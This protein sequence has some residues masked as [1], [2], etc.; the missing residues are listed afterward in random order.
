MNY[1]LFL[2]AFRE[3]YRGISEYLFSYLREELQ[4][5]ILHVIYTKLTFPLHFMGGTQLRLSHLLPRF[6]EDLDFA[7]DKP[8]P[9]FDVSALLELITNAFKE[10]ESGFRC[11]VKANTNR[12]V[13][14]IMVTFAGVLYDVGLPAM[15]DQT[16][17]IKLEVD[18]RPPANARI[19]KKEYRS[20][21]G[22]YFLETF[23]L[24]TGFAGKLGAVVE[25][26]YQKGRDY[27]DLQWYLGRK[28]KVPIN[29]AY[30]NANAVLMNRP[31]MRD[32]AELL[33][34]VE[35]KLK[36]LNLDLLK[37]DLSRFVMMSPKDFDEWVNDYQKTTLG[38]LSDYQQQL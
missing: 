9:S 20:F 17:K 4:Y 23:N 37:T 1:Q 10:S 2:A 25:R 30:Y 38:L 7:L 29:L 6:S 15:K 16:M 28:T 33:S 35:T 12:N 24:S 31:E 32:E 34:R 3:K 11:R 14:K 8:N 22:S 36:T 26:E 13:V 21:S 5:L 27:F 19:E 18:I